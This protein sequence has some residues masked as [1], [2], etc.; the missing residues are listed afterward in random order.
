MKMAETIPLLGRGEGR[1]ALGW[2]VE[3]GTY[4]PR[5]YATAV[6]PRHPSE[7]GTFRSE[8]KN[9]SAEQQWVSLKANRKES[10]S[11]RFKMN[12]YP[13]LIQL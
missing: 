7:E 1:Q 12:H 8:A 5:R 9:E 10:S 11:S 6:A 3:Q 4:P 2:V 13:K